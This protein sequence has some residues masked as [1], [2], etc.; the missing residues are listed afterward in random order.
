MFW[1]IA[2]IHSTR[3]YK[4]YS[5][6]AN[7][8]TL[9]FT[10][11]NASELKS[12]T[13]SSIRFL[14]MDFNKENTT[15]SRD[16]TIQIWQD[17]STHKIFPSNQTFSSTEWHWITLMPQFLNSTLLLPSWCTGRLPSRNSTH[18][19][20]L[21]SNLYNPPGTDRTQSTALLLFH[22]FLS[23][24]ICWLN[25]SITTAI[26]VTSRFVRIRSLVACGRYLATAVSL[27]PQFLLW[28][29]RPQ[30]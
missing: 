18:L 24:E 12:I 19:N 14:A 6:T 26:S 15:V 8:H 30:Y 20:D 10:A 22:V 3:Y 27:V 17:Y 28:T 7:F 23:A 5:A 25:C 1:F 2:L 11:A 29:I 9:E 4:S 21:L 13:V 16:C